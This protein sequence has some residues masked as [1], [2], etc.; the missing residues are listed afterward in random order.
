[1]TVSSFIHL[2]MWPLHRSG[3]S[4]ECVRVACLVTVGSDWVLVKS[5]QLSTGQHWAES[6]CCPTE[7]QSNTH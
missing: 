5:E 4:G 3:M 2:V 1:M 6:D 7:K